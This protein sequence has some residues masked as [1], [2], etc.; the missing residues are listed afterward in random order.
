MG[1]KEKTRRRVS[2]EDIRQNAKSG[3]S[4][5]R[6]SWWKLPKNVRLWNPEKAKTYDLDFL[7][8][9]VKGEN[10][11]DKVEPGTLWYKLPFQI[12]RNIGPGNDALVCPVSIGKPCPICQERTKLTKNWDDNEESIKAIKAQKWDAYILKDPDDEEKVVVFAISGGKFDL[13]HEIEETSED[14]VNFYDVNDDGRTMKVRFSEDSYEGRKFL[15]ATRFDFEKRAEMDEDEVLAKTPCLEECLIVP[16]YE[17]LKKLFLQ[18]DDSAGKG[19]KEGEKTSA[20]ATSTGKKDAKPKVEPKKAEPKKAEKESA[21]SVG[22]RVQ[23]EDDDG[24]VVVGELTDI[25]GDDVIVEDDK[26]EEHDAELDDLSAAEEEEK[27][28]KSETPAKADGAK[29]KKGDRVKDDEGTIGVVTKVDDDDVTI[30]DD[31]GKSYIVDMEDLEAVGD[32]DGEPAQEEKPE[33]KAGD[34]VTWDEGDETGEVIRVHANGEKVRVKNEDNEE[35]WQPIGS[36]SPAKKK[37]GKK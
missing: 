19:K 3:Q 31:D 2:K 20:P 22:D 24:N 18:I 25:D 34:T 17:T 37:G 36:V 11:P 1:T 27:E 29:F 21:F 10:H 16:E 13:N 4:G 35:S 7:P 30:K 8:Y 12:H 9:E 14:N 33:F 32:D 23:F 28:E 6:S 15:K 5:G 26:G